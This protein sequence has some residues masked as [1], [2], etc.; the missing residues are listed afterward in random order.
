VNVMSIS[1]RLNRLEE[2]SAGNTCAAYG[3]PLP[4]DRPPPAE[5]MREHWPTMG[6]Q[7]DAE[8]KP[9]HIACMECGRSECFGVM[10]FDGQKS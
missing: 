4:A 7:D 9:V 6:E 5:W 3:W 2:K 8:Q 10:T 1:N